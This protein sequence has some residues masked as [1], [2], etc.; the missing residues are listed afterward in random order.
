[1]RKT[2]Q[3]VLALKPPLFL[4]ALLTA[5]LSIFLLGGGVY[6]LLTGPAGI[7]PGGA[8]GRWIFYYPFAIN[9]Q[10]LNESIFVMLLYSIGFGGFFSIYQST[11]YVYRPRQAFMWLLIGILL[12]ALAYFGLE[13]LITLK[14]GG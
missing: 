3:K 2:Y 5:A 11:K 13:N 9:D 8:E 6:D 10:T 7:M 12:V 4:I 1:M 14:L